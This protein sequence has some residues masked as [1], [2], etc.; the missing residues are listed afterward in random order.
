MS[1]SGDQRLGDPFWDTVRA[2]HPDIDL[3]LTPAP[4]AAISA[5]G[6]D[7]RIDPVTGENLAFLLIYRPEAFGGDGGVAMSLGNPDTADDV[8][9]FVPGLT[10]EA[11]SL[12]SN[13]SSIDRLLQAADDKNGDRTTAAITWIDY[14]APSGLPGDPVDF[15]LVATPGKAQAG[16]ERFSD[17]IDG[18]RASDEGSRAHVTA[19]GHSYGSTTVSYAAGRYGLEADDLVLIGSPGAGPAAT[20]DE[21]MPHGSVYVG[22]A[23]YDPVTLLGAPGIGA[24]GQDPAQADFG[25]HRFE[26]DPGSYRVQDLLDNH[27]TYFDDDSS[28]LDAMAEVVAGGDPDEVDGRVPGSYQDLKSLLV[29]STGASAAESF[30]DANEW[31]FGW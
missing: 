26:V 6:D 29:G 16:G 12:E 11:T 17:F 23:D 31:R 8:T 5:A 13:M 30:W 19:I 3:V 24:L 7:K 27:S 1:G 21:L 25:A 18:L 10:S 9:S 22:S 2:R 28:S 20:A 14:N 15:A 4:E